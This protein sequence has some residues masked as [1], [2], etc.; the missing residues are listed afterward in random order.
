VLVGSSYWAGLLDWIRDTLLPKG[1]IDE[2]DLALLQLT[3]DPDEVVRIIR[4]FTA[5]DEEA[6]AGGG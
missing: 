1:A 2:P 3:D 4:A 6:E 5:A